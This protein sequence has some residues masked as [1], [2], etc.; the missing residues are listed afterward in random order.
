MEYPERPG[1]KYMKTGK[2]D[3]TQNEMGKISNLITDM[4]L[5]GAS[6]DELARAVRHSMVVID[7]AKHKLDYKKSE[8][9]NNIKALKKKYQGH[10]DPET[11]RY[12]EGT[13][14]IVSRAK[15]QQSVL[16]RQ[17]SPIIDPETGKQSWKVADDLTY[18]KKIVDK[19]T[20]KVKTKTITK[21]Q[22]STKM[23][24]TDDA[25]TLVS[26]SRNPV[27]LVY[28]DYA[29][30]L[31][32]LANQARKEM[33]T[34]PDIPYSPEAK[35]HYQ[36][37]AASLKAKVNVALKNAPRERQA[38]TL[39]N[40]IVQAK[41][42]D[43]PDMTK[44][45]KK[46]SPETYI[47]D[48][49]EAAKKADVAVLFI[50]LTDEFE[51]EGFDRTHLRIPPE[52]VALLSA[53]RGVTENIVVVL[54]G[55]AVVEMPWIGEAKALLNSY[56]GGE[57]SGSAVT[58]ILFGDVNPSGKLAETYPFSLEDT[59]CYNNF[60]GH[61]ATVEYREGLY[62]GYRYYDTAKK[63][64][65]FPF[66][67]GMSYTTFEYSDLKVSADS[68]KDT[69][70]LK[71]SFKIKNTGDRDGAEVAE[72]YV[73]QENSTI[74]R[75]EKELK[76]FKKVFLKAGEEKEVEIELSKRAFAFYDVDLGDWHV[77]TD[78][79]KILVGASSRDIRLE[80]SVKVESTVDAPV[81]DL[82]ETM[83][84]YY[85]ADVMNVPD[86]QFKALL[87][88]EIPE[89]EIHDY[90][91]LTFANTLEDS[92]CGKNGAKLCKMLR[93]F[94]GSEG[95]A[96]S[97][98]LQTPVKNFVSMS[99]GVFSEELGRQL[100]DILNDKKPMGRGILVLIG[101]AIPAVVKGLPNLLKNI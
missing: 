12:S 55:G 56:L 41:V 44:K 46:N 75:P 2:K 83:P 63:N 9:D 77:E 89:S 84:A 79:Y 39:A 14:T 22:K 31:K 19:K 21:T 88:H 98:A 5:L 16:K 70:T 86:D 37:E 32:A 47:A 90:P 29:N 51:S 49:V 20:G 69:D 87:G 42:K 48:A 96:C 50:G 10:V 66:G 33:V 28:A 85:S 43:N 54:A 26:D 97:I 57:A 30:H 68:I 36:K 81:K 100:L 6:D 17:G 61:T 23:F 11:G 72:L 82:R 64:V 92:A 1:M 13:G 45:E 62:I 65:L 101:K 76:G 80:G 18:E 3:N 25:Y 4:T 93:K 52:H 71:V 40:A 74:F 7:A 91:N 27:E 67:F 78:N 99:M 94:V 34:T 59:P 38:Q 15:G 58:D 24:E 8:A 53:I 60:P 95:M 35:A 73:A